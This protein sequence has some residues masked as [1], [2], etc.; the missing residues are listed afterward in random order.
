VHSLSE[1]CMR[2]RVRVRVRARACVRACVRVRSCVS[3]QV[4]AC[5]TTSPSASG[6][7]KQRRMEVCCALTMPRNPVG[8]PLSASSTTYLNFLRW[9]TSQSL[10]T[11]DH[12]R[13]GS[14]E[15]I[16]FLPSIRNDR[17]VDGESAFAGLGGGESWPPPFS[18]L[19]RTACEKR[20]CS[21]SIGR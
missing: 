19:I 11:T 9:T 16:F 2:V 17:V 6:S 8:M 4:G 18:S 21:E 10:I 3:V 1:Q 20:Q 5:L 7:H 14:C 15:S 13:T 12:S